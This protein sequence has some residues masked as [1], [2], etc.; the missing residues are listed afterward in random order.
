MT[1]APSSARNSA[2][3]GGLP[4]LHGLDPGELLARGLN[5]L[6]DPS[7][8]TEAWV[9]PTPEELGR[10]LPQYSIESLLGRGGMG[11]VY[12]GRQQV[13]DRA[14][15]IKLLPTEVAVDES[16]VSRFKREARILA[17][18]QHP[19]IITIHEFGQ[20]T[21]GHLYFVM[22]YIDGTDLRHVLSGPG[23][24]PEEALVIVGQLCD[25]LQAA[26]RQGIIHRDIK[27]E[28]VLIT[29]AGHVKL[30]DFGLARPPQEPG[31]RGLTQTDLA[32][33]TPGY[34]APE[35]Q[36]GAGEADQRSDIFALGVMLYEMLTGQRPQGLFEV[37]PPS[38]H[39]P[40]VRVDVR[41]DEIVLKALQAEP[42][43][44]YQRAGEMGTDVER[45]RMTPPAAGAG[46]L[47]PTCSSPSGSM[48]ALVAFGIAALAG[49]SW[50]IKVGPHDPSSTPT[51]SVSSRSP[52]LPAVTVPIAPTP[53]PG[54]LPRPTAPGSND[55]PAVS[56]LAD[57]A[58]LSSPIPKA[59]PLHYR[60]GF[61]SGEFREGPFT[62]DDFP[63][64][65]DINWSLFANG[66]G[67]DLPAAVRIER[68]LVRSGS[69][70]LCIDASPLHSVQGGV[71][72]HFENAQRLVRIEADVYLK[73]SGSQTVWQFTSGDDSALGGFVGG[74]NVHPRNGELQLITAGFPWIRP[75]FKRDTWNHCE[76]HF[77]LDK[78]SYTIVINGTPVAASVPFLAPTEKLRLFQL[79]S[80][81]GGND[82]AYLDNFSFAATGSVSAISPTT[83][84]DRK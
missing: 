37:D 34:M 14:V 53:M 12:K 61:E 24:N 41:I 59:G 17:Q 20:T 79:D 80:F 70:A 74:F 48:I 18:L 22:E 26:H 77:D 54:A 30:A 52:T 13:L 57:Q 42:A 10:M 36:L 32:V 27:P 35:Q 25:A 3:K 40:G 65:Q 55:A 71:V 43:R 58:S 2:P 64:T 16:F 38:S 7:G 33:G 67:A 8:G 9:A 81:A 31:A 62:K 47:A 75:L 56:R 82:A 78:Q 68:S 29:S 60:T 84:S 51:E 23:L 5:T 49:S 66:A 50:L 15:A 45:I 28:N 39:M 44:R 63:H 1:N 19:R 73:S 83:K 72:A 6:A 21:D 76:L 46:S 11:A 69:Q 4:E